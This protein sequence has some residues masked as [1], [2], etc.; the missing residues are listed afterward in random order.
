MSEKEFPERYKVMKVTYFGTTTLMFDNGKNQLMFDCHTTRPSIK[1]YI[2]GNIDCDT[3]VADRVIKDFK[4]TRLSGIFISHSHHDHVLD[5]PYFAV[6]CNS[7][8]YGTHSTLNYARGNGVEESHLHS[9]GDTMDYRIGDFHIKVFPSL[10]SAPRW[11][12]NDLGQVIDEPFTLPARKKSFKEGGSF[13]FLITHKDRKY[14][15]RPSYNFIKGQ[16]D[17]MNADVLFLG[18]G[19]MSK[20]TDER[21]EEFFKETIDKVKPEIVIPVHWDNFFSP[22]YGDVKGMP[23]KFEKTGKAMRLLADHCME[24]DIQCV[25][26]LPLSSLNV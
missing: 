10:H 3:S 16:L 20:D 21:H 14:M 8:I 4:I 6:K 13:D 22:L 19:G 5:A 23:S 17:N 2:S 11:F 18:I 24:K 9:Y 15:I 7:D 12:N 1:T 25:V 26:Q